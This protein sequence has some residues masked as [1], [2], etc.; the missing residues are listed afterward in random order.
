MPLNQVQVQSLP[1]IA[2]GTLASQ[3]GG[4]QGQGLVDEVH[5]RYFNQSYRNN[6]WVASNAT[7]A[8]VAV[9]L[10]ATNATPL[11][12]VFNPAGSGKAIVPVRINFGWTAGTGIAGCLG[13]AYVN[14]AG[15]AAAGTAAPIS[16]YTAGPTIQM[17]QVGLPYS[18]Q[19]VFGISFSIGGAVSALKMHR[20]SSLGQGAPIT[21]TA[22]VWNMFEEFDGTVIIPPNTLWAPVASVAIAETFQIS[23]VAYEIQWP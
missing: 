21:S 13:Y 23:L 4:R 11:F 19:T 8:P 22:A 3:T 2:D 17:A 9:P 6:L 10:F 15:T 18:G 1:N 14:P 7:G 16:T 12:G 20:W 5:G